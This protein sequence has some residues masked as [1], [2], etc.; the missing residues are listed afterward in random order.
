MTGPARA[1]M[2]PLREGAWDPVL[3]IMNSGEGISRSLAV[4]SAVAVVAVVD[5]VLDGALTRSVTIISD[6]NIY[7]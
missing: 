3:G 6:V 7:S 1:G 5:A 2:E 4:D